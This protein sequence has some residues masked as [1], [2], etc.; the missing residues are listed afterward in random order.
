MQNFILRPSDE[1]GTGGADWLDSKF[2]FS[3][4]D[5]HDP[6][7]MGFHDLRVINE[8]VIA[9]GGGFPMH[10]HRDMEIITYVMKGALAHKDSLGTGATI[11]PGEIQRMSAGS[12]I[13]HSE[14]NASDTE[15]VHLLQI[16]IMP[17]KRGGPPSYAQQKIDAAAVTGQFGLIASRDGRDGSISLQQDADLWLAKLAKGQNAAFTLRPGRGA[18]L[19]V[20]RG[21][22]AVDGQPLSAGDGAHWDDAG[23]VKVEAGDD[24]EVLIF[25]LN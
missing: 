15:P 9:P 7:H 24:S 17:E 1:R 13:R 11:R 22:V 6:D 23:T 25:D 19:Q 18:W 21:T 5:Y 10:G 3:F 20:A 14:F 16:W 4:A 2:S 8:D 12:G